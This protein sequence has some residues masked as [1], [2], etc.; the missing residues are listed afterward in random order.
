MRAQWVLAIS[1]SMGAQV[2][3]LVR[4]MH[5]VRTEFALARGTSG[6][7]R[8]SQSTPGTAGGDNST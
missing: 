3:L 8:V 4:F 1:P 2:L 7:G 6:A 5:P